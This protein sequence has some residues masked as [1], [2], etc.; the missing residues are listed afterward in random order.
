MRIRPKVVDGGD[1]TRAQRLAN[2]A[3]E[4]HYAAVF[5][6]ETHITAFM[7]GVRHRLQRLTLLVQHTV[8][9]THPNTHPRHAEASVLNRNVADGLEQ[10][11]SILSSDD[12]LVSLAQHGIQ[13]TKMFQLILSLFTFRDVRE[14]GQ[15]CR[16]VGE[17]HPAGSYIIGELRTIFA[18]SKRFVFGGLR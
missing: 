14:E 18:Q 4:C 15:S 8:Q 6:Q 7:P 17:I 16:P 13:A 2:R 9:N 10:L 3:A 5:A 12:C 1:L 11:V